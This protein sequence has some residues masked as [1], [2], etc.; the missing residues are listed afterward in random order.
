MPDRTIVITGAS[1]GIGAAAARSLRSL[2]DR[3]VVVGRSREKTAAVAEELDAEYLLA[4]FARLD[5]VRSLAGT[6]LDR[7]PRIDVLA[8]NAGGIMGPR[9]ETVDGHE[10][11]L[12]VNHLAP[13][14]LTNLLLDRLVESRASVINTSSVANSIFAHFDIDDLEARR[15]YTPNRAYGNAKLANILFTRELDARYGAQ[16]ISTAAFHPGAVATSFASESSSLMR[17]MYRTALNKFL[18]SP[19]QGAQ[20]LVWLATSAPGQAWHSGK[21]YYKSKISKANKDAYDAAL[22]ARLWDESERM[23]GLAPPAG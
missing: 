18:I 12:Q 20:T 8:N 14:L 15:K 16:G 23:V 7:Y 21:Y 19:E 13:F 10:K 9:E 22:S 4:D 2:G 3:V 5:D 11:T 1:D 17:V 6:L